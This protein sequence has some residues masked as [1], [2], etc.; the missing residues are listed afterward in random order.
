M[1]ILGFLVHFSHNIAPH[2]AFFLLFLPKSCENHCT[3]GH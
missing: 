3:Y 1:E 2:I